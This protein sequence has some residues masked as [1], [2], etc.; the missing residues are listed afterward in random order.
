MHQINPSNEVLIYSQI[1]KVSG[2]LK[3]GEL[4][5]TALGNEPLELADA[6]D[7]IDLRLTGASADE[8]YRCLYM[9]K[10]SLISVKS[11]YLKYKVGNY[12]TR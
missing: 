7:R 12:L 6:F 1:A 5:T 4:V 9:V 10:M 8:R 2:T 3:I 11:S